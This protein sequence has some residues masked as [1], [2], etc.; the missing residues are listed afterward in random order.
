VLCSAALALVGAA[1]GRPSSGVRAAKRGEALAA[2]LEA[3]VLAGRSCDGC[4]ALSRAFAW[5]ATAALASASARVVALVAA[6]LA[7]LALSSAADSAALS[8]RCGG[9]EAWRGGEAQYLSAISPRSSAACL[10]ARFTWSR[11]CLQPRPTAVLGFEAISKRCGAKKPRG[12]PAD[13]TRCGCTRRARALRFGVR[14]PLFLPL[15]E[16]NY[17]FSFRF[18][19]PN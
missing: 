17:F 10:K 4:G 3:P 16:K 18:P 14:L 11:R 15:R 8:A 7:A 12:A 2:A 9:V 1:G 13:E 19:C 5:A 6:A